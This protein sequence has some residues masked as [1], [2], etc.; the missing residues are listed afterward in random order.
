VK[1]SR[2]ALARLICATVLGAGAS[3]LG[4][5]QHAPK[6]PDEAAASF[7]FV[8]PPSLGRPAGETTA[9]SAPPRERVIPAE[10]ILPLAVPAYP[11][12]PRA[13]R[14]ATAGVGV[15]ITIDPAGRVTEVGLSVYAFSTPGP[16]AAEF[17]AA[18]EAAVA[19]WRFV[20]AEVIHYEPLGGPEGAAYL[21]A[22]GSETIEWSY[23]VAFTFNAAG[24]VLSG[25]G[26]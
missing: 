17:R 14:P 10:P 16:H 24:D 1:H 21:R 2:P 11:K 7:R 5:C 26:R 20:P 12:I 3:L 6:S 4:A 25:W 23:D 8:L 15:R 19:Q 18:V 9:P 13:E 22:T